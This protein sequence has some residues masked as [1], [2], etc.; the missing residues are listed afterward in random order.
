MSEMMEKAAE[1]ISLPD[2]QLMIKELGKHGL[3]VF[4][5]HAHT[6]DGFAPLPSDTVQLESDLVVTFVDKND[7]IL[8]NSTTVGWVW[9]ADGARVVAT[10][11]CSGRHFPGNCSWK[12]E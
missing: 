3:G 6:E 8:E 12:A 10:C 9:D 7:P 4:I 5:P 2:V 11:A 1:A